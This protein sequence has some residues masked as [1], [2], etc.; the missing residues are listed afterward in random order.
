ML[1]RTVACR[2]HFL[3]HKD[4]FHPMLIAFLQG[5][6]ESREMKVMA[7]VKWR[8][9]NGFYLP[10]PSSVA[11]ECHGWLGVAVPGQQEPLC[12]HKVSVEEW[13]RFCTASKYTDGTHACLCPAGGLVLPVL[14]FMWPAC[15]LTTN[16]A[17]L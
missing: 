17:L 12:P 7:M 15:H 6:L 5:R 8:L 14:P 10:P 13:L 11:Q 16:F 1:V 3:K 9:T 4:L 2:N